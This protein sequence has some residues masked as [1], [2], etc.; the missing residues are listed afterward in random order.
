[1]LPSRCSTIHP[2]E[3]TSAD[4]VLAHEQ[5]VAWLASCIAG[6][7]LLIAATAQAT[8]VDDINRLRTTGCG[9]HPAAAT[10]LQSSRSL[11]AVA[12]EWSRGGRLR[13][14]LDRTKYPAL[15]SAS[16]RVEG[17]DDDAL[18]LRTLAQ[19]YCD[20]IV[21]RDFTDIGMYRRDRKVWIVVASKFTPPAI[22][23]AGQISAA[24][25]T[26]VNQAR[27]KAR[28][29]GRNSFSA[30]PPLALS[31]ALTRAASIHAQD[32]ATHD[33]FEHE[34][35]DGSSAAQRVT[36]VGYTW[37][38]VAENIAL[39]PTNAQQVV[40]GWLNSPGHCANIMS[41]NTTEMGIAFAINPR[42]S[43]DIYWSQVF[44]APLNR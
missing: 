39:G 27:S 26:L 21:G 11:D 5:A 34:G 14:A 17:S 40:D 8:L 18:I 22:K 36:R 7:S 41:G 23:E 25:L 10:A 24:A 28:R 38:A 4:A 1:M 37:R 16:M 2:H 31:S 3:P 35:T 9:N 33:H 44:A 6:S 13:D 29:C 15:N 30:V 20:S 43:G 19:A 42:D 32:M 12:R